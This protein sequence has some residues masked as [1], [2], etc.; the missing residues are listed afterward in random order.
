MPDKIHKL[1]KDGK[2]DLEKKLKHLRGKVRKEIAERIR[3]AKEFGEI[4][5]NSEYE[6]AKSEQARVEQEIMKLETILRNA[7]LI[8]KKETKVEQVEVGVI[9]KLKNID[10]DKIFDFEI[11][12]T[13]E[14]DPTHVPPRI[15]DESPIGKALVDANSSVDEAGNSI[16][17]GAEVGQVIKVDIPLGIVSYEVMEIVNM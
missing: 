12:G 16:I 8:E 10:E 15:S 6:N 11:V 17:K 5:E 13:T 3:Q 9:V 4:S 1:T 2:R 7:V 14:A